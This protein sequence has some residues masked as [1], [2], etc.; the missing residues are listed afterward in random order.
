M[1]G[2]RIPVNRNASCP[3]GSGAKFKKCCLGKI[4]WERLLANPTRQYAERL[5]VRG[6][7]IAFLNS[8]AG[9]LQMDR[10]DNKTDM[11]Q[12]K[13]AFSPRAVREVYETFLD[14]WPSRVDLE[15][16]LA[17]ESNHTTGLYTGNY[18]PHSV[19]TSVTRHCLYA[20]K[21]ILVDPFPFPRIFRD[22]YSPLVFPER[23]RAATIQWSILWMNLAPWIDA[24]LVC[25]VRTPGDFDSSLVLDLAEV[26]KQRVDKHPE[27]EVLARQD[28]ERSPAT[29]V[30]RETMK[31]SIPDDQIRDELRSRQPTITDEELDACIKLVRQWRRDHP[32]FID[33]MPDKSGRMIEMV[34]SSTGTNYEMAKLMAR[35]SRSYLVTDLAMRWREMAIDR[36]ETPDADGAGWSPFAKAFQ[37]LRFKYLNDVPL[38]VAL[39]LRND[40]RLEALRGF[41]RR[42]WRSSM[43]ADPYG[44]ESVENLTAE[45]TQRVNEAEADWKAMQGELLQWA[46]TSFTTSIAASV[47]ASGKADWMAAAGATAIS[48]A[49]TLARASGKRTEFYL[50]Q[51]AGFFMDLKRRSQ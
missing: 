16:V 32:L 34:H 41:L 46:G 29:S 8:L 15:R 21:I 7:N 50:K 5:S 17:A 26:T 39:K 23:Y 40:G 36:E 51:P 4:D 10:F 9:I 12:F 38:D 45:L 22:E 44:R 27:L 11:A 28:M 48:G 18:D 1:A 47:I 20:D 19:L 35:S 42:V 31:L 30:L 33:P 2:H 6:K 3:C 43:T 13:Q 37:E 24:G 49:A 14:I 25:F